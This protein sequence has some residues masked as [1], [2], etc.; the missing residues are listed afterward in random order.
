VLC[1]P[2]PNT[3]YREWRPLSGTLQTVYNPE[4]ETHLKPEHIKPFKGGYDDFIQ[5]PNGYFKF[6][7]RLASNMESTPGPPKTSMLDDICHY[8]EHHSDILKD[9]Q[10]PTIFVK[11]ITAAHYIQLTGFVAHQLESI[12]S[13]DWSGQDNGAGSVRR[14]SRRDQN[15]QREDSIEAQWARFRCSQYV[16]DI[17]ATL[18]DLGIPWGDPSASTCKDWRTS[19]KDFQYISRRLLALRADYDRLTT[20]MVGLGGMIRNR[21]AVNEAAQSLREAKTV[22]TLTFIA[23]FFIPLEWIAAL[24]SMTDP[25]SPRG[26]HFWVY[27]AVSGPTVLLAFVINSLIQL[28]YNEKATWSF[29]TFLISMQ[30]VPARIGTAINLMLGVCSPKGGEEDVN[31]PLTIQR[32]LR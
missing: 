32:S 24:F 3:I 14:R 1:D 26:P 19:E 11:K 23:M 20:A 25:F 29:Q 15:V 8:Y 22:K 10:D 30:D 4:N 16:Y 12:R 13:A 17:E 2:P 27:F 28:G 18:L 31:L 21:Q 5:Q 7:E 6:I 9:F